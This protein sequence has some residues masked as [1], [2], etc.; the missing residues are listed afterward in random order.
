[1]D[2][3]LSLFWGS[4]A[5][6]TAVSLAIWPGWPA[7]GV[8][9]GEASNPG[10]GTPE[11]SP[12]SP[13][14]ERTPVVE[15]QLADTLGGATPQA[16]PLAPASH[17]T[18]HG[19]QVVDSADAAT[20]PDCEIAESIELVGMVPAIA[21]DDTT[22]R[23]GLEILR[24]SLRESA[25]VLVS[26]GDSSDM[27]LDGGAP[28]GPASLSDE[29]LNRLAA[30]AAEAGDPG[31]SADSA[32]A[33]RSGCACPRA[34]EGLHMGHCP[35]IAMLFAEMRPSHDASAGEVLPADCPDGPSDDPQRRAAA[36]GPPRSAWRTFQHVNLEEIS[37]TDVYTIQDIP[38][39]FR[40]SLQR[41]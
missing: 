4:F 27:D 9:V 5:D 29:A 30:D 8:R 36:R 28:G 33:D 14:G 13:A 34:R 21:V 32:G 16:A 24:A 20:L 1:M 3:R 41:A 23:L 18:R 17:A 31:Q 39:W 15:T 37:R 6:R 19:T 38:I 26:A 11:Y 22:P 40:G 10:P 12:T 2:Y 25:R 7:R 35:V